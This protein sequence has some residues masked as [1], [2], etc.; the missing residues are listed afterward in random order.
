MDKEKNDALEIDKRWMKIDIRLLEVA[1]QAADYYFHQ[2]HATLDFSL[3]PVEQIGV[4]RPDFE[5][6][7]TTALGRF[8]FSKEQ[9]N[10]NLQQLS[11]G[12]RARVHY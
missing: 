8:Q 1:T 12:E 6:G 7:R 11:G 10:T 4:L 9:V 5:Y 2:D 3:S